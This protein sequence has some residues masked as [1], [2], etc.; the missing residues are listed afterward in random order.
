MAFPNKSSMPPPGM[1]SKKKPG[2]ILAVSISAKPKMPPPGMPDADPAAASPAADP[3][4]PDPA[5]ME[6]AGVIR[7]DHHCQDCKNWEA[8]TGN[9]TVLGPG[10]APDDA[11]LRYFEEMSEDEGSGEDPDAMSEGMEDE[12][13]PEGMPSAMAAQ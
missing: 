4:T 9:C 7:A 12:A 11:C 10:F 8:D 3:T 2:G 1:P 6:K 13:A 5:K